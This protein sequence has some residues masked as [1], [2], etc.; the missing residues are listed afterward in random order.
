MDKKVY[1]T[2][3]FDKILKKLSN[4]GILD[5]TKEALLSLIPNTDISL[6]S[7]L[8]FDTDNAMHLIIK[9]GNPPIYNFFELDGI[10]K[11]LEIGGSLSQ[12][13][14]IRVAT[15]LKTARL[16]KEYLQIDI[17]SFRD[18]SLLYQNKRFE[19][20]IFSKIISEE[21]I[22][23][24]ASDELYKIR[25]QK[26]STHSKIRETL[27]KYTNSQAYKKYLQNATVTIRND[28]FV[29]PV[30]QEFKGEIDG[31]VHSSSDSGATIFIE[32]MVI[33]NLNNA[34]KELEAQEKDEIEKILIYLS[35]QASGFV[36]E[37]ASNYS[38]ILSLD[39][40]FARAKYS[41]SIKGEIPILNDK[42][43]ISLKKAIHPL[44]DPKTAVPIDISIGDSFDTLVI[45]GPNTG[46]KTVSLKTVGLFTLMA[47]CGIAI[48]AFMGSQIAVFKNICADIGD[49]QSIEQSLSTFSSHMTNI[50]SIINNLTEDSL[51][52]FDELG[53]GTDPTEGAAL[54]IAIIEYLRKNGA[55]VIA[56]THYPEIKLY[57]LSQK[58]V[59]NASLEFSLETLMPTYRLIMG[60][61]GKSNAFAISKKL[62]L[63]DEILDIAESHISSDALKFE[64]VL[65]VIDEQRKSAEKEK[66]EAENLKLKVLELESELNAKKE[67]ALNKNKE[68]I[69]QARTQA[70]E[71]IDQA[72]ERAEEIIKQ[73]NEKV[74]SQKD[75]AKAV[76]DTRRLLAD[77]RKTQ[78]NKLNLEKQKNKNPISIKD[79]KIGLSVMLDDFD[80]AVTIDSLPDSKG[81]LTVLAGIMK[82]KTNITKLSKCKEIQAK[83]K[84]NNYRNVAINNN[85]IRPE[86]D[87]RGMDLLEAQYLTEKFIDDAILSR[88]P[89]L[90]I[91]HGKGTGVLRAGIHQLLKNN[92]AIKG[93][94]LGAF[95]EGES[96]VTIVELK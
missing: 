57:A 84:Q 65:T 36:S 51:L 18:S 26:L 83:N 62:G 28:R 17:D 43:I 46:G 68:I 29:L 48:P 9:S 4:Y 45:T 78:E 80:N 90:T 5:K 7:K 23:D 73:L 60:M 71:I 72:R 35:G 93:Y 94:R 49:E 64:D 50:A 92:K 86:L 16:L 95:G 87:L 1:R 96:G 3:E 14:L 54:A 27:Q 55:R 22:A 34:L 85:Q 15:L 6:V 69:D 70:V 42:G 44:L 32:P 8:N 59:K 39:L 52:L 13:E 67:Y 58:G 61:P 24:T 74:K 12:G 66:T 25:R 82:V 63:K 89:S 31:L 47:Q 38:I 75:R 41:L 79:I 81:N 56:T 10:I 77:E 21:E 19:E 20:E 76:G 88:I 33:V 11:R 30:K 2:L 40:I 91:I 53:A 37:I